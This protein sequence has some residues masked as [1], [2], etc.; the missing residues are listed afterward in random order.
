M[1]RHWGDVL[2]APASSPDLA[3]LPV[4]SSTVV[5]NAAQ[6]RHTHSRSM[7]D[8]MTNTDESKAILERYA[9]AVERGDAETIRQL[10]AED[11]TWTLA[12]GDLPIAGTWRGRD[13][14]RRRR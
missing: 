13:A 9:A 4:R 3:S 10:F 11:A 8:E 14:I 6:C 7:E 1:H 2:L 5:R 12:A